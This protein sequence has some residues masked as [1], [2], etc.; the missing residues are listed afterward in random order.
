M[1]VHLHDGDAAPVQTRILLGMSSLEVDTLQSSHS[2][3]QPTACLS[4]W[5]SCHAAELLRRLTVLHPKNIFTCSSLQ[6]F[7]SSRTSSTKLNDLCYSLDHLQN[8]KAKALFPLLGS[9]LG[10]DYSFNPQVD[11]AELH[12][13]MPAGESS[14]GS[15]CLC[16][17]WNQAREEAQHNQF[18]LWTTWLR[19]VRNV[20]WVCTWINASCDST[21]SFTWCYPAG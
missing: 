12:P 8:Q 19:P 13:F 11:L 6:L 17:L 1:N 2:G 9:S 5:Q 7:F 15:L 21:L 4:A 20:T 14:P 3:S 16:Q 18:L 10:S